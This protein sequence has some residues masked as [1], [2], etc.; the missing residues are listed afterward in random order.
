MHWM[1]EWG[2][3]MNKLKALN[4]IANYTC[5]VLCITFIACTTNKQCNGEF[6]L[7]LCYLKNKAR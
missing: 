4:A 2:E 5:P 6:L 7:C 3:V 1:S